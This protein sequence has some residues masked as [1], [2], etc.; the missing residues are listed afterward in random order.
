MTRI[1]I[2]VFN[3]PLQKLLNLKGLRRTTCRINKI[4]P[5]RKMDFIKR[6]TDAI[7]VFNACH[8]NNIREKERHE[9]KTLP[10]VL[11]NGVPGIKLQ[12]CLDLVLWSGI[13]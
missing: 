9:Y 6:E 1:K 12:S 13:M 8:K 5:S 11:R 10:A 2:G 7:Y 3:L 4:E